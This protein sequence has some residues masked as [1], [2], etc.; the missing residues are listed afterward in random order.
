M[1]VCCNQPVFLRLVCSPNRQSLDGFWT[2]PVFRDRQ[3][4]VKKTGNLVILAA[5]KVE[6]GNF[7][8]FEK[9]FRV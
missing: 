3:C 9:L 4:G 1:R 7:F 2:L 6:P 5:E 8:K